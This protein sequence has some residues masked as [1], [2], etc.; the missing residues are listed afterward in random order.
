MILNDTVNIS[1][2]FIIPSKF[3]E[4]KNVAFSIFIRKDKKLFLQLLIAF[5]EAI[6]YKVVTHSRMN[7]QIDTKIFS[8]EFLK[9]KQSFIWVLLF[10]SHYLLFALLAN[11]LTCLHY[12]I[13][14]YQKVLTNNEQFKRSPQYKT[15]N[16]RDLTR[17][18]NNN[19][20]H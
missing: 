5:T 8:Q 12:L 3:Q 1:S 16:R 6:A 19:F 10:L 2:I 4:Q 13:M 7:E 9:E 18:Q 17:N 14:L 20:R 15:F 11:N